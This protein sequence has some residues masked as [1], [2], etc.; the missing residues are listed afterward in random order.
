MG[1]EPKKQDSSSSG[2]RYKASTKAV[3]RI[4]LK[5]AQGEGISFQEKAQGMY[6]YGASANNLF[7]INYRTGGLDLKGSFWAGSYA[8][9]KSLQED[10]M[11]YLVGKDEVIGYSKQETR[12]KWK[13]LS[14]QLQFNYMIDENHSFGAYYK[15]DYHPSGTLT[16]QF[17]TDEY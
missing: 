11:Y 6:Q 2:A 14:P 4:T 15:Y 17:N 7:D 13:G 12:H 10:D 9:A 5:K 3:I 1:T 16:S 8:H